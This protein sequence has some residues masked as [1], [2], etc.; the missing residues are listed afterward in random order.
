[1]T[2]QGKQQSKTYKQQAGEY[3]NQ[4]YETWMPWIEDQYLK[5]FTKDNKA[6]YATKQ[7]LD[8]TKVT[9]VDQ[10][11]N[12]QDGVNNLVGGQVGKGGLAQPIG[13]AV[14]KEGIN[15]AERGGKDEQGRPIEGQGPFGGYGQSAADGVKG[16]ASS[17]TEG[18][19]SAGGWAGASTEKSLTPAQLAQRAKKREK[20]HARRKEKKLEQSSGFGS[21]EYA[22]DKRYS[23]IEY[24]LPGFAAA[25]RLYIGSTQNEHLDALADAPE[26]FRMGLLAIYAGEPQASIRLS[27]TDQTLREI[28]D[29]AAFP[30]LEHIH[31]LGCDD[32][33]TNGLMG[34]MM[35][36]RKIQ[37]I[38]ATTHIHGHYLSNMLI[39]KMLS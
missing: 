11:D 7:N 5:W 2:D 21:W 34:I 10:V 26:E 15:R 28:A 30:N 6:S 4:K 32:A 18:A 37:S 19:K 9:G 36:C 31:L 39:L 13:D 12:L 14:S 20:A 38:V 24:K 35:K 22:P 8:K 27:L 3:Y 25:Q 33:L 16:G 17:V 1:M 29:K 23:N